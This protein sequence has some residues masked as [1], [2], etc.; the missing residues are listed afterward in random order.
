MAV[1]PEHTV[2]Q[3]LSTLFL[4]SSP[5]SLEDVIMSR[6]DTVCSRISEVILCYSLSIGCPAGLPESRQSPNT[7]YTVR[8]ATDV[9]G[10]PGQ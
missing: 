2:S 4:E 7:G 8:E 6:M 5:F 9:S 3:V 1:C 10:P